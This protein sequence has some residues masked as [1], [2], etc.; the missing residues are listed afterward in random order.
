MCL[1]WLCVKCTD[2]HLCCN[3][4][5]YPFGS[6]FGIICRIMWGKPSLRC[7]FSSSVRCAIGYLFY[8]S[9]VTQTTSQA[10]AGSR[11]RERFRSRTLALFW[12]GLSLFHPFLA[13]I[14]FFLFF[15]LLTSFAACSLLI[16]LM[17]CAFL[18]TAPSLCVTG[19]I[20]HAR[21]QWQTT[22]TI[23]LLFNFLLSFVQTWNI[24]KV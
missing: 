16:V 2:A 13:S 9:A 12:F 8:Q 18:P 4:F 17:L 6:L 10:S 22:L 3:S 14:S 24:F 19:C 15:S 23:R 5:F 21:K 1:C 20:K 11:A 7:G